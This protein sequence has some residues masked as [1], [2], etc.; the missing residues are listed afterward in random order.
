MKDHK[1]MGKPISLSYRALVTALVAAGCVTVFASGCSGSQNSGQSAAQ[2]TLPGDPAAAKAA[3]N[4]ISDLLNESSAEKE[5]ESKAEKEAESKAEKETEDKAENKEDELLQESTAETSDPDASEGE[6]DPGKEEADKDGSKEET[7]A[8]A[9]SGKKSY[10]CSLTK[11][12]VFAAMADWQFEFTS[13]A[14]AWQTYLTVEPDGSFTGHYTDA[15]LGETGEGY[16]TNG[17]TYVCEFSGKFTE[18]VQK[19]PYIYE[20]RYGK[21]KLAKEPGTEVISDGL[22]LVFTEPYGMQGTDHV[23]V[24]LPGAPLKDLAKDYVDWVAPMHFGCYIGDTY[25]TDLPE[26]LPF[27]GIYNEKENNGFFSAGRTER[28]PLYLVNRSVWPDLV[29]QKAEFSKDGTYRYEDMDAY[30]MHEVVNLCFRAEKGSDGKEFPAMDL[31]PKSFVLRC[32]EAIGVTPADEDTLYYF[33]MDDAEWYAPILYINGREGIYAFWTTGS[34]EDTRSWSAR[35]TQIGDHV[36]VYALGLSQYEELFAGEAAH[37]F[38][39]SLTFSGKPELLSSAPAKR[40][41]DIAAASESTD[42]GQAEEALSDGEPLELHSIFADVKPAGQDAVTVRE[43][44][45]ISSGSED[46]IKEYGLDPE[47]MADDYA[48]VDKHG[49][50]EKTLSVGRNCPI[51]VQYPP[52]GTFRSMIKL[53]ELPDY[54]A[55]FHDDHV[56]MTLILDK[57]DQVLFMYQN[58]TP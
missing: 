16:E 17:T 38:H 49:A 45:F 35:M 18:A 52:E 19:A 34:G 57:N 7:T 9:V 43:L 5:A 11:E 40:A 23:T 51:Y 25:Y 12:E 55:R 8:S 20:L 54:C 42:A 30:G 33:T 36:Y 13:G 27:C 58:Y 29:S 28:N 41:E 56:A 48:I 26:D 3:E 4:A 10:G 44:V 1:E 22:R 37:F 14:G 2:E 24:Y 21:P 15:N 53:A 46:L 39:T 47:E 50:V 32:L 31:Y 6:Q